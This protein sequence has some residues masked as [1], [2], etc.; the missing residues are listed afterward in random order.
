MIEILPNW[1]PILAHF[2]I[3][4]LL[5]SSALFL[6]GSLFYKKAWSKNILIVAHVNLWIGA[7][8]TLG[9]VAAGIYAYNTVA[10]DAPSHLA[11][12][13]HRNWALASS[14][15]FIIL[16]IWLPEDTNRA[17]RLASYS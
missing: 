5:T 9:T 10:H 6:I 8:L 4:L 7:L 16:A 17:I 12:K 11:M 14:V 3:G 1:H 13:D 2:T 15:L